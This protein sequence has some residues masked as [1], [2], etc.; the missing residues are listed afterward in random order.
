[1]LE[2]PV[3][4][5]SSTVWTK[6]ILSSKSGHTGVNIPLRLPTLDLSRIS[7]LD[8]PGGRSRLRE[9]PDFRGKDEGVSVQVKQKLGSPAWQLHE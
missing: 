8:T 6:I 9:Q 1:M 3:S 5:A 2:F 4:A 7:L